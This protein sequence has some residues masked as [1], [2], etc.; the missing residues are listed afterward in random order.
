MSWS[1]GRSLRAAVLRSAPVNPDAPTRRWPADDEAEAQE[2]LR[3]ATFLWGAGG[4]RLHLTHDGRPGPGPSVQGLDEVRALV[5]GPEAPAAAPLLRALSSLLARGFLERWFAVAL[6]DEALAAATRA[7]RDDGRALPATRLLL[8][9]GVRA[10]PLGDGTMVR[11]VEELPSLLDRPGGR[12]ALLAALQA[13]ALEV[14]ADR[15][16]PGAGA[17][18][19][20]ARGLPPSLAVDRAVRAAIEPGAFPR[21]GSRAADFAALR[22]LALGAVGDRVALCD[23][24]DAR[25]RLRDALRGPVKLPGTPRDLVDAT[26]AELAALPEALRSFAFAWGM[27]RLPF[28]PLAGRLVRTVEEL[29]AALGDPAARAAAR[30]LA[31]RGA[32]SLWA[33]RAAGRTL[34]QPLQGAVPAHLFPALCL[35]LGEAPPRIEARAGLVGGGGK[36]IVAVELGNRDPLR[37]AVIDLAV[38][39]RPKAGREAV[40]P[41]RVA[42]G[43]LEARRIGVAITTAPEAPARAA[44]EVTIGHAHPL[45]PRSIGAPI[46]V[47]MGRPRSVGP[48]VAVAVAIAM[49]LAGGALA[50]RV[51]ARWQP[52]RP[53]PHVAKSA[54]PVHPPRER[55]GAKNRG[56]Y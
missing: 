32:L 41:P 40:L 27:L 51:A 6:G 7:L 56:R 35:E 48:W 42:L 28:L 31:A 23:R 54:P 19:A 46:V 13:G 3:L 55:H 10:L 37:A 22:F 2:A 15:V 53:T 12:E 24:P 26:E 45:G 25:D 17:H 33:T 1:R 50:M 4:R 18:F 14:W 43:P 36:T 47:T 34:P 29:V 52:A 39:V 5:D 9:L 8:G 20:A 11:A 16:R 44:I 49:A 30:E 21:P 38:R